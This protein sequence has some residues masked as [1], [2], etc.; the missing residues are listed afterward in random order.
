MTTSLNVRDIDTH[1]HESNEYVIVDFYFNEM[2]EQDNFARAHFR[3]EIHLVD[4]LKANVLIENDILDF[5]DI[6]ID[7]STKIATIKSCEIIIFVEVKSRLY[8]NV[9]K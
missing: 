6:V 9:V 4:D 7:F 1:N 8:D 3:R 2:N 5:E